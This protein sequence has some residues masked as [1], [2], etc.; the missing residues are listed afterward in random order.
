MDDFR[1]RFGK[2]MV[3]AIPND[4]E[5]KAAWAQSVADWLYDTSHIRIDYGIEYEGTAIE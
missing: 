2:E 4:M 1:E 3:K 5:E